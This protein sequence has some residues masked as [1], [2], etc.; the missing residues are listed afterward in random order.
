MAI[1]GDDDGDGNGDDDDDDDG[2]GVAVSDKMVSIALVGGRGDKIRLAGKG[3]VVGDAA[4]IPVAR[5]G[6]RRATSQTTN[7]E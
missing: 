5:G 6:E 7:K 2:G 3:R 4:T 1:Y